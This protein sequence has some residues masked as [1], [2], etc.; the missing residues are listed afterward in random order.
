MTT[1]TKTPAGKA[2]SS[3]VR[4]AMWGGAVATVAVLVAACGSGS[5]GGNASVG[6]SGASAQP[7]AGSGVPAGLMTQSTSVGTVLATSQGRTV[8]ELVGNPASNTKCTSACQSIWPPVMSGGTIV[9]LHG[10]PLFTFS[11]DSAAGQA[12]GQG[13]TD[14][15]G[16]WVAFHTDGTPMVAG[17]VAPSTSS[18]KSS[19]GYRY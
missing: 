15:W 1:T 10:H 7:A 18:S 3:K 11:G 9:V 4:V 17:A 5:S 13:A 12:N 19:G 16:H 6:T 14:T 8:Y 2:R